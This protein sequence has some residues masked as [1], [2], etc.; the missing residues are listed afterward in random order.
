[1]L[2][3]LACSTSASFGPFRMKTVPVILESR[4]ELMPSCWAARN[5]GK[6]CKLRS[7]LDRINLERSTS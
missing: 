2:T 7:S 6:Y 1:M 5:P 4:C 3:L